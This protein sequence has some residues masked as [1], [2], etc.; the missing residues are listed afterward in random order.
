MIA[1]LLLC[2]LTVPP[3]SGNCWRVQSYAYVGWLGCP[4]VY[5]ETPMQFVLTAS[6]D[7]LCTLAKDIN[8]KLNLGE[9]A[10]VYLSVARGTRCGGNDQWGT[11]RIRDG[12]CETTTGKLQLDSVWRWIDAGHLVNNTDGEA[13]EF[14][15]P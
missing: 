5:V 15:W 3:L 6:H 14:V 11:I 8:R 9:R 13:G 7:D 2:S 4:V 10:T 12:K 1:S